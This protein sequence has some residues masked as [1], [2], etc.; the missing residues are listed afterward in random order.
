MDGKIEWGDGKK[1]YVDIN[2]GWVCKE[3]RVGDV[4]WSIHLFTAGFEVI[5]KLKLM[6]NIDYEYYI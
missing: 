3:V 2:D 5:T 4:V 6:Q 1:G